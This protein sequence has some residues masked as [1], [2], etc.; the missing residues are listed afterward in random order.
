MFQFKIVELSSE[1]NFVEQFDVLFDE[2]L[3]DPR[4][5]DAIL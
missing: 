1:W 2:T 5:A 4:L 3:F